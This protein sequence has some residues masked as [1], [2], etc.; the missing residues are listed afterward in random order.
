MTRPAQVFKPLVDEA[1]ASIGK[2][3]LGDKLNNADSSAIPKII[4]TLAAHAPKAAETF[5]KGFINAACGG[6]CSRSAGC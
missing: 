2:M 6:G 3:H 4:D 1:Q 5:V